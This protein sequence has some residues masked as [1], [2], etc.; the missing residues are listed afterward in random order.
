MRALFSAVLLGTLV[1][2]NAPAWAT[3]ELA[4]DASTSG[5]SL[6]VGFHA[7]KDSPRVICKPSDSV[8]LWNENEDG[9]KYFMV[10]TGEDQR[11]NLWAGVGHAE[12]TGQDYLI[13]SIRNL[14]FQFGD[15]YPQ[16]LVLRMKYNGRENVGIVEDKGGL[17]IYPMRT[18]QATG[19]GGVKDLVADTS[20]YDQEKNDFILRFNLEND[21]Y[22]LRS[23]QK[24]DIGVLGDGHVTVKLRKKSLH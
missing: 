17:G 22:D 24:S 14:G 1:L 5:D 9:F 20:F 3:D 7:W 16:A 12:N 6:Q 21:V 2:G 18:I 13:V 8:Y 10:G 19:L 15:K 23:F 4:V 11:E